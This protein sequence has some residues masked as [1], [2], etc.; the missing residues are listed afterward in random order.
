MTVPQRS[1]RSRDTRIISAG[2][3]ADGFG[4]ALGEQLLHLGVLDGAGQVPVQRRRG[5]SGGMPAG[6]QNQR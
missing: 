6:P 4:A 1:C 5:S 2:G 3:R